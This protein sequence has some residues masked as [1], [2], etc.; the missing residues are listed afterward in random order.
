MKRDKIS[1]ATLLSALV[2][3]PE[4]SVLVIDFLRLLLKHIFRLLG[5]IFAA[6]LL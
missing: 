4:S 6:I 1:F 3:I 5:R 2:F